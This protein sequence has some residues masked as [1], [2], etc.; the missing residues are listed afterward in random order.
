[1]SKINRSLKNVTGNLTVIEGD[2]VV[3]ETGKG[4]V[5]N[6][7]LGNDAR[8]KVYDDSGVKTVLVEDV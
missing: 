3:E 8:V 4:V 2:V 5:I 1:M 6:D 7:Q